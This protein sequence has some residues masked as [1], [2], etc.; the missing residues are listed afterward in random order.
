MTEMTLPET[1][2][3]FGSLLD[4]DVRHTVIGRAVPDEDCAQ[5]SLDGYKR[6]RVE[7]ETYPALIAASN[8]SVE[9]IAVS[10]LSADEALRVLYFEGEEYRP[11]AVLLRYPRGGFDEAYTFL[12]S[13][14][15][16]LTD[17]IWDFDHWVE[18]EL[19][20]YIPMTEEWMDGYGKTDFATQNAVWRSRLDN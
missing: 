2:F 3:F 11:E 16:N 15:L 9:G 17:E 14:D 10:N 18:H 13:P 5:V 6:V 1:W 12:A 19:D 7:N 4:A 20:R 8:Q